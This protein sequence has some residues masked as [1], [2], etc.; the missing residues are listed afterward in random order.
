MS[1]ASL[2][3]VATIFPGLFDPVAT[4]GRFATVRWVTIVAIACGV[5]AVVGLT[6]LLER[7]NVGLHMRAA[8][9]DFRTARLLGVNANRVIT[10]AVVLSGVLAAAGGGVL[11]VQTPLGGP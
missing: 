1:F 2:G 3:K 7:T 9:A 5:V 11:V 8:A 4:S 10:L 6:M